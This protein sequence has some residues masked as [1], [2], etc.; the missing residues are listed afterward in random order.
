MR[1]VV[2]GQAVRESWGFQGREEYTS[3]PR[4]STAD[5]GSKHDAC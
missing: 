3:D 4:Q 1:N 2:I 5:K